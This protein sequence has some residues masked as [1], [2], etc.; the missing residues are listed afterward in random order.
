MSY[1]QNNQNNTQITNRMPLNI[2][3]TSLGLLLSGITFFGFSIYFFINNKDHNGFI[4]M[5][6]ISLLLLCPGIYSAF[7]IYGIIRRWQGYNINSLSSYDE[8]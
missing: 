5:F 8:L 1:I 6:V 4:P 3:V 7:V 2:L